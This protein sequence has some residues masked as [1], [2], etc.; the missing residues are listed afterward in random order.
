MTY[1]RKNDDGFVEMFKLIG[2]KVVEFHTLETTKIPI[3][4]YTFYKDL[5]DEKWLYSGIIKNTKSLQI[6]INI[7]YSAL[8]ER[9]F[10]SPKTKIQATPA[11]LEGLE[12]IAS[13]WSDDNVQFI[14]HAT[15]TD[16]LV[17]IQESFDTSDLSS[18]LN[19][20]RT[21]LY[22]SIGIPMD[23]ISEIQKANTTATE[24]LMQQQNSY[25]N[26]N[27]LYQSAASASE[28]I[29]KILI[30]LVS[31]TKY[32]FKVVNGPAVI[33]QKMR[34]RQEIAIMSS[35]IPE[36]DSKSRA[37][38]N[39]A[40]CDSSDDESTKELKANLIAN[41][42]PSITLVDEN[43]DPMVLNVIN[44]GKQMTSQLQTQMQELANQLSEAN[45]QNEVLNLELLNNREARE[46]DL[47]KTAMNNQ[48]TTAIEL[49]KIKL[50]YAKLGLQSKTD[51]TQL[52]MDMNKQ[53]VE[54]SI[55]VQDQ[56][57][58]N[59]KLIF[60][61]EGS[62]LNDGINDQDLGHMTS[63]DVINEEIPIENL[64]PTV[65]E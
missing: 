59:D 15:G 51:A 38:L 22:A 27:D 7:V 55:K 30:E 10:R 21:A 50:E 6:L 20:Y 42:D 16:P 58:E 48:S 64:V 23:G 39:L 65:E 57:K 41:L 2:D 46:A 63:L 5:V 36:S 53:A 52:Q 34:K 45:K 29:G 56:V 9:Y 44:K 3:V 8:A 49:E 13:R 54:L 33:S 60:G 14:L 19:I 4:R 17:P 32:R 24:I 31:D 37:L 11:Q 43:Q 40:Y 28:V 1:Y 62:E 12:D 18:M 61:K 26:L 25:S 35:L 47:A